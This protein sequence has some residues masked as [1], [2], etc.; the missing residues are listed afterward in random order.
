MAKALKHWDEL[1]INEAIDFSEIDPDTIPEDILEEFRA[2]IEPA[3]RA[4]VVTKDGKVVEYGD[5]TT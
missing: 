1:R 3:W 4:T 5:P 2:W